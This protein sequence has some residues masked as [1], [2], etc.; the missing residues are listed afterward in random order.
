MLEYRVEVRKVTSNF[1]EAAKVCILQI[2]FQK[3]VK[4]YELIYCLKKAGYGRK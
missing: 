2:R 4:I 1:P 3:K